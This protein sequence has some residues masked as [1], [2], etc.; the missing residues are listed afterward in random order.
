[1]RAVTLEGDIVTRFGIRI[2][3]P[4]RGRAARE[5]AVTAVERAVTDEARAASWM[6]TSRREFSEAREAERIALEALEA[7]DTRI[8]GATEALRLVERSQSESTCRGRTVAGQA[9]RSR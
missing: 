5:A 2:G 7:V 6:T 4:S 1:M 9:Q 3:D 8:A